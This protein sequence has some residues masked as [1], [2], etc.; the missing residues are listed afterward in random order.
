MNTEPKNR[1]ALAVALA[2]GA[3]LIVSLT[4]GVFVGYYGGG[5]VNFA[6][7]GAVIGSFVGF[8]LWVWRVIASKKYLQ[9]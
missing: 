8:G 5:Y 2:M 9:Q 4:V 7:W 6:E 3:E 1:K